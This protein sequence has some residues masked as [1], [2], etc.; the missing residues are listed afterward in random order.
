MEIYVVLGASLVVW[1]SLFAYLVR[2]DARV[3]GLEERE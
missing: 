1:L 3:R 2:V